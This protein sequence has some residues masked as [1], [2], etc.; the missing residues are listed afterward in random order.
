MTSS[1]DF[2]ELVLDQLEGVGIVSYRRMFGSFRVYIDGKPLIL[3]IDNQIFLKKL[4]ELK[5]LM[6]DAETGIPYPKLHERYILDVDERELL[7]S[8]VS[9]AKES[10]SVK[11]SDYS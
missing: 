2:L 3:I 10:N 7:R 9:I 4:P 8:A 5:E 11:P 6:A 1:Q